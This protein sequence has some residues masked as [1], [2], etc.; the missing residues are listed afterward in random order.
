MTSKFCS[1][2]S[3]LVVSVGALLI[4]T[5]QF[6]YLNQKIS[7]LEGEDFEG[8]S[9]ISDE[10][11]S[12]KIDTGI[13]DYVKREMQKQQDAAKAEEPQDLSAEQMSV[14]VDDDAVKGDKKATVTIVEFSEYQC[15][16]CKMYFDNTYG[17]LEKDY[18]DTG[19]VKY[20]FRDYPLD[21]HENAYPAALAA[22][23]LRDQK[24]DK[25]Y[26]ELHNKIFEN[27]DSM[28]YDNFEKW[29]SEL[30]ANKAKFK[31]CFD[32][33]KFKDEIAKDIQDGKNVGVRGTPAFFVNGRFLSGAQPY[34]N[35]K[36]IIDEELSK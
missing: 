30:G 2:Y 15:P 7:N 5:A 35:F 33:D 27:Q 4:L 11:L 14:L 20:V 25:A 10:V 26:F 3:Y 28:S 31:T 13:E 16:F 22:E 23:C 8:N 32:T 9:N 34:E 36:A 1:K 18:I 17:Q 21:F 19:K 24:G 29:A 12:Q 6:L